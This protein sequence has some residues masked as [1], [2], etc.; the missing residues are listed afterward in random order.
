MK[1]LKIKKSVE[2]LTLIIFCAAFLWFAASNILGNRISHEYPIGYMAADAI[3]NYGIAEGIKE[4]GNYLY[5]PMS[6]AGGFKDVVGTHY[7]L[8][9]HNTVLSHFAAGIKIYDSLMIMIIFGLLITSLVMYLII[10]KFNKNAAIIALPLMLLVS[11]GKFSSGITWGQHGSITS[12]LFLVALLWTFS[13][14]GLNEL[15]FVIIFLSGCF[16]GH[17]SIFVY[18]IIFIFI[19][20]IIRLLKKELKLTDIKKLAIGGII[21]LMIISYYFI[22][23]RFAW[24]SSDYLFNII[25]VK[26]F[27]ESMA[28]PPIILSKDFNFLVLIS[29]VV[30][31]I[32]SLIFFLKKRTTIISA[33]LFLSLIGLSNYVGFTTRAFQQRYLW[34]IYLSAFFGIGVYFIIKLIF[35]RLN[36]IHSCATFL[37]ILTIFLFA[38]SGKTTVG[39]MMDEY[40]WDSF[41]WIRQNINKDT[42]VYFF[43][44]DIGYQSAVYYA[45]SQRKSY[46]I[47]ILD[48]IAD[49]KEST[50]R[51]YYKMKISAEGGAG[52]PYRT[53]LFK[54][55]K[56]IAELHEEVKEK[57]DICSMEYIV[58]DKVSRQQPLA[59]YNIL[60]MNEL[61]KNDWIE[62]VYSN[63]VVSI[64]KNNKP[65]ED[66]IV[67][68]RIS[69]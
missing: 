30:G 68:Q 52:L 59:N 4:N 22:I 53:S 25:T 61:I 37:L 45:S 34:P 10:R 33:F 32:V 44:Q 9:Y 2:G 11:Y 6:V 36:I 43:Y 60:I 20:I 13:R 26:K 67:E 19:Y 3:Q 58:F 50:I 28:F 16:F 42:P 1:T 49:L 65:E 5:Q 18:G 64:L 35:K 21:T 62:E 31:L 8:I 7:P 55:G 24:V 23:F 46:V 51:R 56:H 38:Y 66:C 63:P 47:E 39:S 40:H 54:Y 69:E 17:P 29:I 14:F 57:I 27:L 12:G 41:E 48:F 15:F